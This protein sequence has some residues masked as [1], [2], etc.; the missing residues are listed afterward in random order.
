M[1]VESLVLELGA[2]RSLVADWRMGWI[3]QHSGM[4]EQ[5][6]CLGCCPSGSIDDLS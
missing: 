4:M 1:Q 2:W 5:A 3:D 6:R